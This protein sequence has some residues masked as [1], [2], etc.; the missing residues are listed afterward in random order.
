M[1]AYYADLLGV[2]VFA[3]SGALAASGKNMYKDLFGLSFTGFATAVG[4]GTIRDITL[5]AYPVAWVKDNNYLIAIFTGILIAVLLRRQFARMQ[6]VFL[7]FDSIGIAIYT[8][9]GM[10]KALSLNVAPLAAVLMGL[11]TAVMGG[12]IRDTLINEIP[13]IFRKQI[14]ATAC[15]A[16]A[17]LFLLLRV[18]KTD[19]TVNSIICI[20]AIFIIRI[21]SVKYRWSLPKIDLQ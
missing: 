18:L 6:K 14:Y 17:L 7:L 16:G 4:G 5:G 15:I 8:I 11:F 3:V 9:V 1:I 13:Q 20:A 19:D 21:L 12:V 10:Q 2:L